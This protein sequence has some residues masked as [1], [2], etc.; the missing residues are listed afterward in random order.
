VL[1]REDLIASKRAAGR[2][3]DLEDARLLELPDADDAALGEAPDD[4]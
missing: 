4:S 1:S 3:V 2:N